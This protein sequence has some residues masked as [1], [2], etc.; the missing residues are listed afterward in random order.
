MGKVWKQGQVV[1]DN[2]KEKILDHKSSKTGYMIKSF[3]SD[4]PDWETLLKCLAFES[5]QDGSFFDSVIPPNNGESRIGTVIHRGLYFNVNLKEDTMLKYI[6]TAHKA[7]EEIRDRTNFNL[8]LSGIKISMAPYD[9]V[10]H[11]DKWDG[12]ALQLQGVSSWVVSD[13]DSDYSEEFILEPG[14]FLFFPVECLHS[15]VSTNPRATAIIGV[16]I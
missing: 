1:I 3:L 15:V 5:L 14:D 11:K 4:C 13:P 7:M 6:P 10:P 9:V 2:L 8:S 12:M 16:S